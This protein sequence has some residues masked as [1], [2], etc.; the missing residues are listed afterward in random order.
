MKKFVFIQNKHGAIHEVEADRVPELLKKGFKLVDVSHSDLP[1]YQVRTKVGFM[2]TQQP[3][4]AYDG[5]GRLVRYIASKLEPKQDSNKQLLFGIPSE[6]KKENGVEKQVLLTMFEADRIPQRRVEICN[7]YYDHLIVP[8]EFCVQVFKKCG[9]TIPI[10]KIPLFTTEF[11]VFGVPDGPFTF[12][13]QN[14]LVEGAQK[15]WDITIRAFLHLFAGKD[16]VRLLLKAREHHWA[17]VQ[18]YY[19]A[20]KQ[21]KNVEIITKNYTDYEMHYNFYKNIHA[22]VFPSRGEGW[23]LPPLEAM[24]HGIPTILT[25][26]HSHTEFSRMGVEVD[27]VGSS[28]SFYVGRVFDSGVGMW[29][30]PNIET[31]EKKMLD[32]YENYKFH[33]ERAVDNAKTIKKELNGDIFIKRLVDFMD[34]L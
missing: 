19:D 4:Y 14:A 28:Y 6:A 8:S 10:T 12:A 1:E 3:Q 25:R 13:H 30:E 33:K 16:D 11:E 27:V 26:A 15:G 21:A 9:V 20:L 24:A 29:V 2:F 22:F 32:V 18:W 7:Q 5:Y 34:S 23:G 31:L 17:N